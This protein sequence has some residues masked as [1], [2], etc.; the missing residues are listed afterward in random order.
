[1]KHVN[2][3]SLRERETDA[4][5]NTWQM[6]RKRRMLKGGRIKHEVVEQLEKRQGIGNCGCEKHK[7]G[8]IGNRT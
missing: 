6:E 2:K 8:T 1:M 5:R 3:E 7:D 4:S